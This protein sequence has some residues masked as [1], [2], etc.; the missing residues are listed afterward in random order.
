LGQRPLGKSWA[1]W[2]ELPGGKQ[3]PDETLDQA[4]V[5]EL[6]EELGIHVTHA[7]PWVSCVYTY[8]HATVQLS[9]YRVTAWL[10]E[11]RGQ[12]NQQLK[13]IDP[14]IEPLPT[15]LI[16]TILPATRPLLRWLQLPEIYGI[17]NIG[18]PQA[19]PAFL[20][21]LDAALARGVRLVQLRE[22]HWPDGP[23]SATLFATLDQILQR[24]R[25]SGA[26]LLINSVHPTAWWEYAD[27]VQLR[28]ADAKQHATRP[29]SAVKY[30]VG[31]SA[32]DSDQMAHAH[33][34]D[35]DFVV[36]GPVAATTTHPDRPG[37]GW[38][39]FTKLLYEAGRPVYSIGGQSLKTLPIAQAH[40]AHGIAAIRGCI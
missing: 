19:L 5:R 31:L 35:T 30:W 28:A 39:A 32:H 25:Q 36:I 6:H 9:C 15:T 10:G 16:D 7:T 2:W 21:R 22:P 4:L 13:W 24:C 37:I 23:N 12:E 20:K 8:P 18:S 27:G 3:Q 34:L 29:L 11:P 38:P 26:K 14:R 40:G 17:S 33:R 1:G